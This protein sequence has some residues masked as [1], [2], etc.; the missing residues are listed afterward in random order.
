M[1]PERNRD[2]KVM[3]GLATHFA[4]EHLKDMYGEKQDA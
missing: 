1:K 4:E 3:D 2:K